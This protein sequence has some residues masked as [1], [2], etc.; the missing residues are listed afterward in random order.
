MNDWSGLSLPCDHSVAAGVVGE[1]HPGVLVLLLLLDD[2]GQE[3]SHRLRLLEH[4][5]V[6]RVH[7][8]G[9]GLY[10]RLATTLTHAKVWSYR[11]DS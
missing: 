3:A 4:C 1:D 2:G 6:H 7:K 9:A 11:C 5:L 8:V 10:I